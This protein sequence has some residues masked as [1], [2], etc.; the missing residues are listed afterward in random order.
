MVNINNRE[1]IID[2][3]QVNQVRED[4]NRD[5]E[6]EII[7][8]DQQQVWVKYSNPNKEENKT[9]FTRLYRTPAF[10]S[11]RDVANEVSK[12]GRISV[13]GSTFKIRDVYTAPHGFAVEGQSYDTLS[14]S[15]DN[16]KSDGYLVQL[17]EK[18]NTRHDHLSVIGNGNETNVRYALLLSSETNMDGLFINTELLGAQKRVSDLVNNG[19]IVEVEYY[20]PVDEALGLTLHDLS[21][22]W[23]YVS[24]AK[25]SRKSINRSGTLLEKASPWS[26]QE[27]G[28]TQLAADKFGPVPTVTL[29]R[30]ANGN[31]E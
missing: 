9:V 2:T 26:H 28:G 10:D 13:A 12:G 22:D 7:M 5:N 21:R 14:L 1:D 6:D 11:P 15:W 16:E 4:L 3:L 31:I 17:A 18:V 24:V 25:L 29:V 19:T 8:W 30:T 23:H 20:D 27:V